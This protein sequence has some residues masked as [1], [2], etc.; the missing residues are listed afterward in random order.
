[1]NIYLVGQVFVEAIQIDGLCQLVA[2]AVYCKKTNYLHR[3][4]RPISKATQTSFIIV[5]EKQKRHLTNII[6]G[7]SIT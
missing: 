4:A 2:L 7:F 3:K 1:M 6:L 5:A